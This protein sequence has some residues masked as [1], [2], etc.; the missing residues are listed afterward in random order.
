MSDDTGVSL[1]IHI[2]GLL[3]EKDLRDQ[4]RFDAQTEALKAALLAA[5]TATSAALAAAKEAVVKAEAGVN[6]RLKLLNELRDGVATV[7]QFNAL[8]EKLTDLAARV[9]RTEGRAGGLNA[10]WGYLI[11][12]AGLI[13]AVIAIVTSH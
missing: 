10:S 12:A 11:G 3:R 1:L 2:E 6:E 5:Q 13:A 4:Q 8:A 7:A 9:D